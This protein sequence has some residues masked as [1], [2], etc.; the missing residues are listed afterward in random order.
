MLRI[1][2]VISLYNSHVI[3]YMAANRYG[4]LENG[5]L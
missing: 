5:S 4:F 3:G 1:S 2:L